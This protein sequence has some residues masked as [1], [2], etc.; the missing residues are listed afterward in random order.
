[1][2]E[3]RY[4]EDRFKSVNQRFGRCIATTCPGCHRVMRTLTIIIGTSIFVLNPDPH[5]AWLSTRALAASLHDLPRHASP[6]GSKDTVECTLGYCK[7]DYTNET[8]PHVT[9]M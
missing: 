6:K 5:S 8:S 9:G 2:Y 1:M 3:A 4:Q 7:V